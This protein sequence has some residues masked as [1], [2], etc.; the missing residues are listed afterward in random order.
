MMLKK[1]SKEKAFNRNIMTI[2]SGANDWAVENPKYLPKKDQKIN[3]TLSQLKQLG[4][5]N[6]KNKKQKTGELFSNNIIITIENVSDKTINKTLNTLILTP[7][8]LA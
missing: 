6:L 5:V 8:V 4:Y 2:L 1:Y 7:I 3:I